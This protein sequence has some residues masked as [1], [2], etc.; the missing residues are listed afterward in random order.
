M[1]L[2][3]MTFKQIAEICTNHKCEQCPFWVDDGGCRL[4]QHIPPQQD[5]NMEVNT[6]M[7][8][9]NDC[10][11]SGKQVAVKG[12]RWCGGGGVNGY[13]LKFETD[14]KTLYKYMETAA[15]TCIDVVSAKKKIK[16]EANTDA[17]DQS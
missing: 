7:P 6:D 5:L 17:E 9:N 1:K 4:L 16:T 10:K 14:D 3:D 8:E 13:V 15:Q 12:T 11:I 2:G